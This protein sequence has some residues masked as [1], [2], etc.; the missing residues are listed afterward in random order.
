MRELCR[1]RRKPRETIFHEKLTGLAFCTCF[2]K[3]TPNCALLRGSLGPVER[4]PFLR[5]AHEQSWTSLGLIENARE[6]ASHVPWKS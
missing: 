3:F 5:I 1:K 6:I 2:L 4:R